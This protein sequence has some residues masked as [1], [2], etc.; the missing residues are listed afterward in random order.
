MQLTYP[1]FRKIEVSSIIFI[2]GV[3]IIIRKIELT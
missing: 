3:V 1:M 2:N